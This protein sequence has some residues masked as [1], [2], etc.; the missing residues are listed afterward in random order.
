L[1][2]KR[3]TVSKSNRGPGLRIRIMLLV[4]LVLFLT[5]ILTISATT[6][7]VNRVLV[8]QLEREATATADLLGKTVASA[9]YLLEQVEAALG[10]QMVVQARIAAHLVAVAERAGM[11]P[12]EINTALKDIVEHT[13]LDEFWITD[14]TAHAYLTNTDVEFTFSP[15]PIEQPQASLFFPLL[16]QQNGVVV[17]QARTR[18]IDDQVFKYAGVSGVDQPRIVQV[19]Y[20]ASLLENLRQAYS[21]QGLVE[22]AVARDDVLYVRLVDTKM[23]SLAFSQDAD[24]PSFA[25]VGTQDE[26]DAAYA[27]TNSQRVLR[28]EPEALAV[29]LPILAVGDGGQTASGAITVYFSTE[30]LR[31]IRQGAIVG[32]LALGLLMC[33][34]GGIA[35]YWLAGLIALPL[36]TM[37]RL[38]QEV[39]DGDLSRSIEVR[40]PAELGQLERALGQMTANLRAT[41]Q[42]IRE[43]ARQVGSSSAN[44]EAVVGELNAAVSQQSAAVAETTAAMEQLRSVAMQIADGAQTVSGSAAHTQ[45]DVQAG[46]RA[47]SETVARMEEIRAGNEDSVREILLLGRKAQQISA[48]M[49]LIDDIAAQTKLIAINASIEAATAGEAGERF[50]VVA[51]Q[52]RSLA[53]NVA[54]STEEI[55]QRI[56]EIQTATNELT[57]AAE[58]NTKKIDHGVALSQSTQTALDQIAASADQTSISASQ[59]SIST[60]QQQTAVEQVVEALH[61]LNAEVSRVAA[62]STQTSGVVADLRYLSNVLNE[63]VTLFDLGDRGI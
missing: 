55:R 33:V 40:R 48:V 32:G 59:I 5:V 44:I 61:N 49:D 50:G 11:A 63:L 3:P 56:R 20:N 53:E 24:T 26:E 37:V 14:E 62:S 13:I 9:Q 54:Q 47:V 29:T 8:E 6:F 21:V 38:T 52:V 42:R 31:R 22:D 7:Q 10:D 12:D 46:L 28:W 16:N 34:A 2:Q 35:S 18:E 27:M 51:G 45:D 19:G 41:I 23:K 39:A 4:D 25:S 57:I 60:R 1:T 17:Q 43:S 36:Q 58:Q 30:N 15:S